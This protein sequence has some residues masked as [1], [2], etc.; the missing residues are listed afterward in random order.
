[1]EE[2]IMKNRIRLLAWLLPVIAVLLAC[3]V[4]SVSQTAESAINTAAATLSAETPD[5][6]GEA[7]DDTSGKVIFEDDFSDNSGD[8]DDFSEEF[9]AA[10][11]DDGAYRITVDEPSYYVMANPG[12]FKNASDVIVEVDVLAS[13]KAPHMM[14]LICRYVD[15]DNFYYLMVS[16]D[17]WYNI[18]KIVDG[19]EVIVGSDEMMEDTDNAIKLGYNDNHLRA[20]CIGSTLAIYANGTLLFETAD[21]DFEEGNVGLIAGTFEDAPIS[22]LFDNFLVTKP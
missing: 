19:E 16:S 18:G 21:A 2:T 6:G 14:G 4:S 17:G 12:K 5:A 15:Y 10:A 13:D 1:L 7:G 9:G 11:I 22:V 8:W 20:E 3:D